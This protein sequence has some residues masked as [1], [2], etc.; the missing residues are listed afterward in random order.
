MS[1]VKNEK[2]LTQYVDD[3]V[4]REQSSLNTAQPNITK[5]N[6]ISRVSDI[7]SV[8]YDFT[9]LSLIQTNKDHT[10]VSAI[11]VLLNPR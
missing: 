7:I 2:K 9:Q 6:D 3:V 1:F 5:H 11:I 10:H 8:Q 4:Y